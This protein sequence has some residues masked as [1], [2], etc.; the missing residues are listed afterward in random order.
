MYIWASHWGKNAKTELPPGDQVWFLY[1][2]LNSYFYKPVPGHL[3]SNVKL[4]DLLCT[5]VMWNMIILIDE[6]LI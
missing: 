6:E 5:T 2:K 4:Y 1:V 3:V